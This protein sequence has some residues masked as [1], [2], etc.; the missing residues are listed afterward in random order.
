M[1]KYSIFLSLLISVLF[2]A[3]LG[4]HWCLQAFASCGEQRLL[5]SAPASRCV[6]SPYGKAGAQYLWL[7]GLVAPQHVGS[8]QTRDQ[9]CV[10]CTGRQILNHWTT[11]EVKLKCSIT[12][13]MW[14]M[15]SVTEGLNFYFAFMH[16]CQ[17]SHLGQGDH[18]GQHRS[19]A[20]CQSPGPR[21]KKQS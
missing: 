16:L 2:S 13:G 7:R 21:I 15:A 10:P 1:R 5:S 11:R 20:S 4:R 17:K 3:V 6:G 14:N 9:T 19:A 18:S 12:S 8:S